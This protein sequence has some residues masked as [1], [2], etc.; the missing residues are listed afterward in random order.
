MTAVD[1]TFDTTGLN[2]KIA[3]L[4]DALIGQ[5]GD[6]STIIQDQA[7]LLLKQV[8]KFT[9]PKSLAQ[10]RRAVARDINKAA[11]PYID[12]HIQN[13]ILRQRWADIT[14]DENWTYSNAELEGILRDFGWKTARVETWHPS[15]HTRVRNSRGRVGRNQNIFVLELS[16][17]KRYVKDIQSRVGRMIAAWAATYVKL[18]GTVPTWIEKHLAGGVR[19]GIIASTLGTGTDKPSITFTNRARGIRQIE[20][21]FADALR[22]RGEA[23]TKHIKGVLSGYSAEWKAGI[24]ITKQARKAAAAGVALDNIPF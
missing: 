1:L 20:R 2:K 24:R 5:G 18:G 4:H 7:R 22:V 13:P 6:A 15:L 17:W 21:R 16:E 19:G 3:Q 12:N 14:G 23:I 9:P 8:I 10:G 11:T